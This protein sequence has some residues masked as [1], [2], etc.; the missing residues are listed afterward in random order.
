MGIK[1]FRKWMTQELS[2]SPRRSESMSSDILCIDF[3]SII[4]QKTKTFEDWLPDDI[5][6]REAFT[7]A[8]LEDL[9][10]EEIIRYLKF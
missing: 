9:V 10:T 4:V 7:E 6:A 2:I 3:N 8:E 1:H 5:K